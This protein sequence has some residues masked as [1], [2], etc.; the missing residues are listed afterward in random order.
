MS[1]AYSKRTIS[2]DEYFA[3]EINSPEK[4]EYFQGE[5]VMMP[6]GT[7]N[8]SSIAM[9]LGALLINALRG[10]P[11]QAFNGDM[12]VGVQSNSFMSYPDLSIACPPLEFMKR[13]GTSTLLNPRV[14]IEVLSKSSEAYDRGKKWK[15]YVEIPSFTEYVLVSQDEPWVQILQRQTDDTWIMTSIS[16]LEGKFR[17]AAIDAE[18]AMRD[19]Y[20]KVEFEPIPDPELALPASVDPQNSTAE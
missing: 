5:V 17:I 6:G 20:D 11:C 16:S 8:H 3:I 7:P 18:F 2:L 1:S 4:H 14:I 13:L 15:R 10:K 19:V 12:R 9:N